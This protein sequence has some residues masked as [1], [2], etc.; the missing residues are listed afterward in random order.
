MRRL[1]TIVS[2]VSLFLCIAVIVIS[3]RNLRWSESAGWRHESYMHGRI[4][5][6]SW[7]VEAVR[8]SVGFYS[9]STWSRI[10]DFVPGKELREFSTVK[11]EYQR[12]YVTTSGEWPD[13]TSVHRWF[14]FQWGR[15]NPFPEYDLIDVRVP[16]WFAASMFAIL[17]AIWFRKRRASRNFNCC[18]RCGYDLRA[19]P[20]RCPECGLVSSASPRT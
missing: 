4:T 20:G 16:G 17:P 14:G 7:S 12:S 1:F 9:Y 11:W 19:T 3:L 10:V 2:A 13:N 18:M 15:I 5:D 6:S 8:G